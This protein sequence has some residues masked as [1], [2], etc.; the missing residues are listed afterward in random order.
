M[1]RLVALMMLAS[2]CIAAAAELLPIR[3]GQ[4][5]FQHRFAEQPT[6]A[7]LSLVASINGYHI[8]LINDA[9]SSVFPKGIIAE[10]TLMWHATSRQWIIGQE[11]ADRHAKDVGGCSDGPEVVDLKQRIYWTC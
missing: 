7:S 9:D 3:S 8:K 6:V 10:G 11:P 2:S 4:Y 1:W 5:V